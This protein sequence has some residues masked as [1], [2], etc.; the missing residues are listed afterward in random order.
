MNKKIAVCLFG[1]IGTNKSIGR[2]TENSFNEIKYLDYETPLLSIKKNV[3][4]YNNADV[5]IH[6]WSTH[7]KNEIIDLLKPKRYIFEEHKTF[8]KPFH[9]R[10]HIWSRFYTGQI[11]NDLKRLYELENN[12][13]YD[14]VLSSRMD[15]IW[16]TEL[17]LNR[18]IENNI[19]ASNW[20]SSK[21]YGNLGH[22][23]VRRGIFHD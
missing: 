17:N 11:S 3:I 22:V 15:L 6:S 13:K 4:E 21:N 12:F 10:N 18:D 9:S 8:A 23:L 7:K 16:F 14:I 20:N 1:S 5:F 19:F 2:N